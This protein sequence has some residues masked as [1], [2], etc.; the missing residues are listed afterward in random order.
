MASIAPGAILL[1]NVQVGEGAYIGAGAVVLPRIKI[2]KGAIVGAGAVVTKNVEDGITVVG[3][4]A[5]KMLHH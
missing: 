3:V 1:G 4:P 2:G 5:T